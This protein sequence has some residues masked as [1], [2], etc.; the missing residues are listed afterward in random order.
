M[1][2]TTRQ[3]RGWQFEHKIV[4]DFSN[5]GWQCKRMG[6]LSADNPDE[7][8]TCNKK[9]LML[10]IEAKSTV[11]EYCYMPV[12]QIE[13]FKEIKNMFRYYPRIY[14][15]FA[16][17]FGSK[18]KKGKTKYHYKISW[19]FSHDDLIRLKSIRCDKDGLL[20][21]IRKP[22]YKDDKMYGFEFYMYMKSYDSIEE[23]KKDLVLER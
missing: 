10:I 13:R 17:K 5:D 2:H 8:A 23:L 14:F 20:K 7:I 15:V 18:G 19:H 1:T 3:S 6:G 12:E 11:G 16:F 22:E 9:G 21:P 4:K